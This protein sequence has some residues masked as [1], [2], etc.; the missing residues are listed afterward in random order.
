M[1]TKYLLRYT[2]SDKLKFCNM[3]F[4]KE[5]LKDIMP[6]LKTNFT[7]MFGQL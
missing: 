3:E 1:D 5:V 6:S 4:F 7:Y 2:E